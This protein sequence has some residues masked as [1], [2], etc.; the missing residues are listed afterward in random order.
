[1]VGGPGLL[2]KGDIA[3]DHLCGVAVAQLRHAFRQTRH[4]WQIRQAGLQRQEMRIK[5]R[6]L[7]TRLD[8]IQRDGGFHIKGTGPNPAQ[9]EDMAKAAQSLPQ[10]PRD[11]ANIATL[12]TSHF[13]RHVIGVGAIRHHQLLHPQIP[14]GEVEFLP[15]AGGFV[16]PNPV[17]LYGGEFGRHLLDVT[18]E[19][20][21]SALDL[22]I[23]R[24]R[25]GGCDHLALRII[26]IG[27][28]SQLHRKFVGFQGI[29]DVG[30]GFG[31]LPQCHCQ[32]TGSLR[33]QRPRM[34]GFFGVKRPAHFVDHCG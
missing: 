28:L 2:P 24:A 21:Q 16:G 6:R 33:V 27:G 1:M 9:P 34:S 13:Q 26:R 18:N 22:L 4:L 12:A 20:T 23:R 3:C 19:C 31:R 25:V 29:R 32:N 5:L 30:N 11:R 10:I 15:I 8:H 14:R 7:G 17:D